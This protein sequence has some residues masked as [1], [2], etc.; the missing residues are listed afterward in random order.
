MKE[1]QDIYR[2]HGGYMGKYG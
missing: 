1:L 2:R